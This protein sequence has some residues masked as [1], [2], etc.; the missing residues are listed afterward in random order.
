MQGILQSINK[1]GVMIK[2]LFLSIIV[3]FICLIGVRGE[4]ENVLNLAKQKNVELSLNFGSGIGKFS[5]QA[6]L[7]IY[8]FLFNKQFLFFSKM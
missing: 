1:G 2:R 6:K 3:F 4:N 8:H 7:F 5:C